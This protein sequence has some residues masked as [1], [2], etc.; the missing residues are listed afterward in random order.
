MKRNIIF[1]VTLFLLLLMIVTIEKIYIK[2][3]KTETDIIMEQCD[4]T[5]QNSTLLNC[6]DKLFKMLN[7]RRFVNR[8]FFSKE[9][10]EQMIN[11]IKKL[12]VYATEN[13]LSDA[14]ATIEN[15]KFLLK[16][17]LRF[18]VKSE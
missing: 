15:I 12:K 5:E 7:K 10:T 1:I 18:N 17:M 4:N 13:Q 14:K 11:E 6:S 3:F 8:I 9:T 16:T 2:E